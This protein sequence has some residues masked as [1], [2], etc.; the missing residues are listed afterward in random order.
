MAQPSALMPGA[1]QSVA[2]ISRLLGAIR[3]VNGRQQLVVDLSPPTNI[4]LAR[5]DLSAIVYGS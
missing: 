3:L 4:D 5:N 2:R 1:V